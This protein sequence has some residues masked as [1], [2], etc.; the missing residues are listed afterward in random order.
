LGT[1]LGTLGAATA[2]FRHGAVM[3]LGWVR[4]YASYHPSP[5]NMSTGKL[6]A[7]EL[8]E[9]LKRAAAEAGYI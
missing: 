7:E 8:A 1:V 3:D 2:E 4:I 6:S 5:R 9:V